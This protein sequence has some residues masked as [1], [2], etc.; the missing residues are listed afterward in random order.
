MPHASL[1]ASEIL[2]RSGAM[3]EMR[4]VP[5]TIPLA[6]PFRFQ[7]G[8]F[9]LSQYAR[10]LPQ[11][12]TLVRGARLA[13]TLFWGFICPPRHRPLT[14]FAP[15]PHQ[16]FAMTKPHRTPVLVTF[17]AGTL[18]AWAKPQLHCLSVRQLRP[19]RPPQVASIRRHHAPPAAFAKPLVD[20][21][22]GQ[23]PN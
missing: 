10:G 23:A 5:A 19:M 2:V 20:R 14:T 16:L 3:E 8:P 18:M 15:P 13:Q 17:E 22:T 12:R 6:P 1:V 4:V 11:N 7:P 9:G 21:P